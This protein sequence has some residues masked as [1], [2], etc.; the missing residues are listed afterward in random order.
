[1]SKLME[2]SYMMQDLNGNIIQQYPAELVEIALLEDMIIPPSFLKPQHYY[3][4]KKQRR[5]MEW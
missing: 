4:G 3:I 5:D 1:M 2:H